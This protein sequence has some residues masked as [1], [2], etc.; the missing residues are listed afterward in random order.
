[1]IGVATGGLM[2]L[3]TTLFLLFSHRALAIQSVY[4]EGLEH[5]ERST[6]EGEVSA[7]LHERALLF[8]DRSNQYLFSREDLQLALESQF[9]FTSLS[10][11]QAGKELRITVKERTSNLVWMTDR[12]YI[13]DLDGIITRVLNREL[14]EDAALALRLPVFYDT[15]EVAVE[16][17][18]PVLTP[19]EI[20]NVFRFHEILGS[21][22]I[23]YTQ[24]H[25][26]RL[27]GGWM[28]IVT[29]TGYEI[30]F[31][32]TGDIEAQGDTLKTVLATQVEDRESLEYIDLR[33]GDHV[34]F[35]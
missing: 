5:I 33:F 16:I 28:S 24:T 2:V 23:L 30:Y 35:K 18:L 10:I 31:D 3:L 14:P 19:D 12:E 27:A 26:N 13:V 6:F 8:F 25:V 22:G 17:G 1:M 29:Q 9:T 32:V 11:T 20:L 21:Q 4:V 15:N 7:Y 34:Y